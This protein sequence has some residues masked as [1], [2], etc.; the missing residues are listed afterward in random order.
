MI[1]AQVLYIRGESF[2]EPE[3]VPPVHSDQIAEPL[4][5]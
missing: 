3:V 5:S 4:M 1:D 2:V